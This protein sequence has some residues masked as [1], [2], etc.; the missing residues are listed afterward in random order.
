MMV[1][2]LCH[3]LSEYLSESLLY[4]YCCASDVDIE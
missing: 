2:H 3:S 4:D 1:I